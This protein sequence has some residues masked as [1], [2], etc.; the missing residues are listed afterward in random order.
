MYS[1]GLIG[2]KTDSAEDPAFL[3]AFE[4]RIDAEEKI[5]PKDLDAGGL[6]PHA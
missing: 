6:S 5:E 3:A 1:Q 2:A 4:A